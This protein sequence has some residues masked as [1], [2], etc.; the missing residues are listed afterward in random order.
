MF[1][2]RR[3]GE[4]DWEFM[5]SGR[6]LRCEESRVSQ[7]LS[8]GILESWWSAVP[9]A[10]RAANVRVLRPAKESLTSQP[11]SPVCAAPAVWTENPK[12]SQR[13][14]AVPARDSLEHSRRSC[15]RRGPQVLPFPPPPPHPSPHA[16][17]LHLAPL[18]PQL[19]ARLTRKL[20]RGV[21]DLL[22]HRE[23]LADR[24]WRARWVRGNEGAGGETARV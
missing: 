19:T 24:E 21:K 4:V 7:S 15:H 18:P 2:R 11:P 13:C 23:M 12:Y 5:L 14:P 10:S 8:E 16:L 3:V 1:R 20:Q 22:G 17:H 6:R 9:A